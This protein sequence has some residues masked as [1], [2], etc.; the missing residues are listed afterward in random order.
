VTTFG[1]KSANAF[2]VKSVT[3]FGVKSAN[4]FGVNQRTPS[5]LISERVPALN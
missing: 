1:V 2:G 4:A 3:T 5:A